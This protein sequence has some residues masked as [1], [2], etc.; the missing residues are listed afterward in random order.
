LCALEEGHLSCGSLQK[1]ID[2]EISP[3][4]A[5]GPTRFFRA[6]PFVLL[7]YEIERVATAHLRQRRS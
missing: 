1:R 4:L 6:F 5:R 3:G 2:D 7:E